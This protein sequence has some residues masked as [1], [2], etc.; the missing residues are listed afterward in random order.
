[1]INTSLC[2]IEQNN[3]YL[4]L[5]RVKKENDYNKDKWIGIGGKFEE[6]ESP[7]ECVAREVLEETGIHINPK[8]LEYRGII[9]FVSKNISKSSLQTKKNSRVNSLE[10]NISSK[11][12]KKTLE[13]SN[14]LKYSEEMNHNQSN[15]NSCSALAYNKNISSNKNIIK[16]AKEYSA[17]KKYEADFHKKSGGTS[18]NVKDENNINQLSLSNSL[19]NF[20]FKNLF[21]INLTKKKINESGNLFTNKLSKKIVE[22]SEMIKVNSH[23]KKGETSYAKHELLQIQ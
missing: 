13:A 8:G 16:E 11:N 6:G 9:T 4:M 2:Y 12:S 20:N 7:E 15:K 1:M 10:K 5:H 19:L 23:K 17:N 21:K 14:K 3:K 18:F 22:N